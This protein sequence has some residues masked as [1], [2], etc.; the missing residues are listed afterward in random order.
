[1]ITGFGRTGE[2]F[3]LGRYG[4][5]PDIMSFAKGVT[6]GYLPLGGIQV[7]DKIRDVIMS[8]PADQTWMHAYTYS[9]HPTCTAVGLKNVQLMRE[10]N[11]ADRAAVMGRRLLEGLQGLAE[12]FPAIGDVRGLGLICAVELV[13]DRETKQPSG[14]GA[15]VRAAAIERGLYTRAIGDIIAFA[16][17]LIISED[18]VDQ[19]V[20][21]TGQAIAAVQA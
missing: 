9:A 5:E 1:M 19:M 18:E 6:S 12:E 10:M 4:I 8:A 11:L 16:P 20:E 14:T 17:P 7:S 21:I 2:W 15:K 13:A 3:G